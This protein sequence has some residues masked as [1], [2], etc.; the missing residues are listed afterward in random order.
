MATAGL[1]DGRRGGGGGGRR[2]LR[3]RVRARA[4]VRLRGRGRAR[5]RARAGN[6][7]RICPRLL[8]ATMHRAARHGGEQADCER[9][10]RRAAARAGRLA[11]ITVRRVGA[12]A[13]GA[14]RTRDSTVPSRWAGGGCDREAFAALAGLEQ[15]VQPLALV[16]ERRRAADRAARPRAAPALREHQLVDRVGERAGAGKAIGR[17]RRE[18][19]A[20][21]RLEAGALVDAGER[22]IAA[23]L[24]LA[25]RRRRRPRRTGKSPASRVYSSTPA[26]N[27][28]ERRI[29][30]LAPRLL[31]RHERNR[32]A[33]AD[34]RGGARVARARDAEVAQVDLAL[35][36]DSTF[37]GETS[38]WTM[39]SGRPP[40]RCARCA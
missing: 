35:E 40:C 32:P 27:T 12:A 11:A 34:G 29:D 18:R 17:A 26:E 10:A 36:R 39:P 3:G 21:Q 37:A 2:R 28:S 13:A 38:R 22:G 24:D 33:D 1:A 4:R 25:Q 20:Q 8:Q 15:R 30:R 9:G 16:R 23:E 7:R 5:D 14:A 31:G 6:G 19:A